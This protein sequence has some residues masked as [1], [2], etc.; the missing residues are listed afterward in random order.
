MSDNH[1]KLLT[2]NALAPVL[3]PLVGPDTEVKI[4]DIG[5]HV[6]PSRLRENVQAAIAAMERE[7]TEIRLGYGLCGRGLEGVCSARS[8]LTLPRVD[9]CIGALLGSRRRHRETLKKRP[10]LYFLEP[11]WLDTEMNIFAGLAAGM[12]RIPAE[13]RDE[14]IRMALRHYTA[15]ALLVPDEPQPAAVRRCRAHARAFALEFLEIQTDLK[16]LRRLIKGPWDQRDFVIAP[17]G[18]PIPFF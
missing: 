13:R 17:P 18:E 10:G 3:T 1:F 8:R 6:N 11:N 5:L 15:L 2:C 16:L 12:D 14:I 9:D 4:L 7:G